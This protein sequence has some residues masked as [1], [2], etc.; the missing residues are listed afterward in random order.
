[1]TTIAKKD[2]ARTWCARYSKVSVAARRDYQLTADDEAAETLWQMHN[3]RKRKLHWKT[4]WLIYNFY[5]RYGISMARISALFHAG[6]MLV[7]DIVY[8]WAN[9]LGICLSKIFP[10]PKGSQMLR[11]YPKSYIKKNG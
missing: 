10:S 2:C 4:E 9:L 3:G 7:H 8:A 11:A 6:A 1:M 5:A